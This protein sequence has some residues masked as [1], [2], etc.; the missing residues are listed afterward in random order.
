MA[1][2]LKDAVN[3]AKD[4]L[5]QLSVSDKQK[6]PK[7][8]KKKAAGSASG[9]DELATPPEYFDHRIKIFDKL[10]AKYQQEIAGKPREDITITLPDG[11]TKA[12]KSWETTPG[13][14]ARGIAKSLFE[15]VFISRVDGVVWDLDRPLEKSCKLELLDFSDPEAKK[16][17]WHSSAHVL[18]EAAEKRWGCNLCIGPPIEDGFYYEMALPDGAAVYEA[19]WAPLER[20][21]TKAIKEKQP[22]VRLELSK[23]DLLEMFQSNKYKQHI[24]K[25][26]IPDGTSTTVY[27]CGPLIDL[28]RGPHGEFITEISPGLFSH[29]Q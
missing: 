10:L 2:A 18:G 7:K 5:N 27:R 16:V 17:Y 8:E 9:P 23:E 15:K 6:Q 28:C 21:A 29:L 25:D 24:I 12:G 11:G 20:V 26:K 3:A 14:I 22:F 1:E 13:D 4:S 19:D